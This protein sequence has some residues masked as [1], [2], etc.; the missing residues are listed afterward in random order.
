M[1]CFLFRLSTSERRVYSV[2]ASLCFVSISRCKNIGAA[3]APAC[4]PASLCFVFCSGRKKNIGTA[5]TS[6]CAGFPMFSVL[7]RL[8]KVC[9]RRPYVFCIVPVAKILERRRLKPVFQHP[10][11]LCLCSLLVL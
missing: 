10:Y 9:V 6:L 5:G 8:A 2:L 4:V 11:V 7:L 1:F 3:Q